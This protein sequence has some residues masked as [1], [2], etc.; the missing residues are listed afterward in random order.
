[1][2]PTTDLPSRSAPGCI[3]LG[4]E[5]I[6]KVGAIGIPGKGWEAQIWDENHNPVEKGKVGEL[7]V[8]GVSIMKCYYRDEEA[9]KNA[10][11]V[12]GFSPEIWRKWT[13]TVLFTLLTEKRT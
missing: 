1:M 9:T 12:T 5:N 7:A 10:C 6:H 13:R 4:V 11:S 8:K 3:H 2:I